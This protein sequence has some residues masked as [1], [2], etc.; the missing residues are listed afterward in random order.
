[1]NVGSGGDGGATIAPHVR[2][3]KVLG[4]KMSSTSSRFPTRPLACKFPHITM[5]F[6]LLHH[7]DRAGELEHTLFDELP[8][9]DLPIIDY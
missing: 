2:R 5:R 4:V 3:S 9:Q 6:S 8:H 7:Q 1:M